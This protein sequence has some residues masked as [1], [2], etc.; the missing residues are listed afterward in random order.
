MDDGQMKPCSSA[1]FFDSTYG[2]IGAVGHRR[3][4]AGTRRPVCPNQL[5]PLSPLLRWTARPDDWSAPLR[6]PRR[7]SR[8]VPRTWRPAPTSS[9]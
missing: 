2:R 5:L 9:A 7:P 6:S 4:A 1:G 3:T 8:F